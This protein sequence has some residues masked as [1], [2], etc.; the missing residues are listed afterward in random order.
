MGKE[1]PGQ[2]LAFG[3]ALAPLGAGLPP[4]KWLCSVCVWGG[5]LCPYLDSDLPEGLV[6]SV[7]PLSSR[8]RPRL[9][10]PKDTQGMGG[11]PAV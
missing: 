3:V 6:M 2:G 11:T 8:G 5:R 7:G 10:S 1:E 9:L 4:T